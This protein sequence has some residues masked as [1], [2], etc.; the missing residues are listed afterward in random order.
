METVI[1][2]NCSS[3]GIEYGVCLLHAAEIGEG[4]PWQVDR[5][6]NRVILMGADLHT[7]GLVFAGVTCETFPPRGS[8]SGP[9]HRL[10][11]EAMPE[12]PRPGAPD[13]QRLTFE[14]TAG[15]LRGLVKDLTMLAGP[16]DQ[17]I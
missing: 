17:S 13:G 9:R 1:A 14:I 6:Q 12:F 5:D 15:Q 2:D 11:L 3:R 8:D 10:T 16:A 7:D 4:A